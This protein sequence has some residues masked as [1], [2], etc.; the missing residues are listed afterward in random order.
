MNQLVF[1]QFKSI[2]VFLQFTFMTLG[3]FDYIRARQ[4]MGRNWLCQSKKN[5]NPTN[6][7]RTDFFEMLF[8]SSSVLFLGL[9]L[10]GNRNIFV[11][12]QKEKFMRIDSRII[13]LFDL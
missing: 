11:C 9:E 1:E 4:M 7:K 10:F 12:I 3:L 8:E 6:I 2:D 5:P 13:N